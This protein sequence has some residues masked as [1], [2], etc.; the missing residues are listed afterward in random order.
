[1]LHKPDC[2][3]VATRWVGTLLQAIEDGARGGDETLSNALA[4]LSEAGVI[5]DPVIPTQRAAVFMRIAALLDRHPVVGP[6][7]AKAL[8]G[9]DIARSEW[10]N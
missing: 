4:T 7:I 10:Q 6:I 2:Y 1:M 9:E 5:C 3:D 8:R